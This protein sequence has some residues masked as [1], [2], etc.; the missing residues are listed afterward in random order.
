MTVVSGCGCTAAACRGDALLQM[1]ERHVL[2]TSLRVLAVVSMSETGPGEPL[3]P[4]TEEEA[5][6]RVKAIKH[7]Y[8][9]GFLSRDIFEALKRRVEASVKP[10]T[11]RRQPNDG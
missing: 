11:R 3:N 10:R 8:D 9:E 5:A 2:N 4:L 7:V 1:R 6:A